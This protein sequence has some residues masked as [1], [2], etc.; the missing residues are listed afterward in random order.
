MLIYQNHKELIGV[1][2]RM[3]W[4]LIM[5]EISASK[6]AMSE[7]DGY[8]RVILAKMRKKKAFQR[9]KT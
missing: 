8:C 3:A 5:S 4:I 6:I 9:F 2:A 7:T 1:N